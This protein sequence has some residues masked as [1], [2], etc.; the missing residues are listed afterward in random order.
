MSYL[1]DEEN[2]SL[3]MIKERVVFEKAL[4]SIGIKRSS[5]FYVKRLKDFTKDQ[6]NHLLKV[7]E[8]FGASTEFTETAEIF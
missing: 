6:R 8:D 1:E 7:L 3:M 5:P 4:K 2:L